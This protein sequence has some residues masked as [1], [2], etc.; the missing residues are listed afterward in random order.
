MKK[1]NFII[2]TLMAA[3]CLI[4][5][6]CSKK[7]QTASIEKQ[8]VKEIW[9]P[10][11]YHPGRIYSISDSITAVSFMPSARPFYLN[12]NKSKSKKYLKMLEKARNESVLVHIRLAK[13][14]AEIIEVKFSPKN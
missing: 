7:M 5:I 2:S 3:T 1:T 6:C 13:N 9:D 14:Q 8:K 11:S 10:N 12:M 4:Q